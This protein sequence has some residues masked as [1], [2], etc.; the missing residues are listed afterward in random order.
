MKLD[1]FTRAYITCALW[2]STTNPPG[3]DTGGPPMDDEHDETDIAPETLARMV[4]ECAAF[5]RDNAADLAHR[6]SEQGGHDFWLTRNHHG[7]GFWETPDWPEDAGRRLT[8]A[9]HAAGERD[10]YIGDDGQI[11]QYPG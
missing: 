8:A 1:S 10:L 3:D 11:Y 7:C 2:S 4:S 6:D 9:A 5:Q